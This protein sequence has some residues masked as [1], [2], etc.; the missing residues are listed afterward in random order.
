AV[1]TTAATA[2]A[3]PGFHAG[4]P[5]VDER[6]GMDES[7]SSALYDKRAQQLGGQFARK[8]ALPVQRA[9]RPSREA[10]GVAGNYDLR[11]KPITPSNPANASASAVGSGAGDAMERMLPR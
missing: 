6:M 9:A 3:M 11:D 8:P 10:L 1:R 2:S 5:A 7:R 4:E